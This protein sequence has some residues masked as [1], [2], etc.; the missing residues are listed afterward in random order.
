MIPFSADTSW[1]AQDLSPDVEELVEVYD[2]SARA[3]LSPRE[4]VVEAGVTVA[5]L[6]A[7]LP[8]A[9][10]AELAPNPSYGLMGAFVLSFA[11]LL[12]IR[13]TIGFGYAAPVQIVLVP[14]LLLCPPPLVPLL[15][16]AGHILGNLPEFLTGRRHPTRILLTAGDSWHAVGPAL[17]LL[18]A[19]LQTPSLSHWPIYLAALGAQ[20][21]CDFLWSTLRDW[22]G[23]GIKPQLQ[24]R[25]FAWTCAVDV[26]LSP[27][28]LLGALAAHE[29]P[30]AALLPLSLAGLFALF[31]RERQGRIEHAL[32]LS[33]AY[34]G[35][36]LLLSDV[37]EA[38]D[39]YTG[40]HSR[41]VVSLAVAVADRMG[42]D[43]RQRRNVEFGALL[44][45][46][47]KIAVPREILNKPGPLTDAE[48]LVIRTHTV[49]GQRMLDRV[50]GVLSDVGAIVR[51]SHERWDGGGYPD[52][53][54]GEE[55]PFESCIVSCCDAF[56]AMTTD[57]SY[58]L[59][60]PAEEALGELLENSG[61]QFRPDVVTAVTKVVEDD[62]RKRGEQRLGL[63]AHALV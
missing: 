49:E 38:D 4:L 16:A 56:N 8:F 50:G 27:I 29:T 12:R 10:T 39:E 26:L 51:S 9:L 57:R 30:A 24:A 53:L 28:G 23:L 37:L 47:G 17:V 32:E 15:V 35:T 48:W 3:P 59:G 52:G 1:V 62:L 19:G 63:E 31:A 11:L 33:R 46:V 41:D 42:V 60:R 6:A 36:T 54:A 5:F 55:I 58:R 45:D 18:A 14:M 22:L 34:R 40:L 21:F 7:V 61:T 43:S 13:F 25:M 44:H 20:F 2:Q